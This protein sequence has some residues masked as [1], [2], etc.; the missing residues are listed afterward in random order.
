M[1]SG[2]KFFDDAAKLAGSAAGVVSGVRREVEALVRQ[3]LEEVLV[4]MDLV[5]REEFDA[6]KNTLVAARAEQE[7]LNERI[8]VLQKQLERYCRI[9]EKTRKPR[10]KTSSKSEASTEKSN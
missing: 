1:R 3:R 2:N 7:L 6:V 10:G 5:R 9:P 8:N 4:S